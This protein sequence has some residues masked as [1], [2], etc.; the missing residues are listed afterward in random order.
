MD[1]TRG[2][3][4]LVPAKPD[5]RGPNAT[6]PFARGCMF[7]GAEIGEFKSRSKNK[8]NWTLGMGKNMMS[9][10]ATV[11]FGL[12][13]ARPLNQPDQFENTFPD[14]KMSTSTNNYFP[15]GQYTTADENGCFILPTWLFVANHATN[16]T[17]P[18]MRVNGLTFV[19]EPG[20]GY[21][22]SGRGEGPVDENGIP[23]YPPP[24]HL[25]YLSL[26]MHERAVPVRRDPNG[27][28]WPQAT[29]MLH[30]W[31]EVMGYFVPPTS[32]SVN[33]VREVNEFGYPDFR[34]V[35][36]PE[37]G[38]TYVTGNYVRPFYSSFSD[39]MKNFQKWVGVV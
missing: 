27:L 35:P 15:D 14:S 31:V 28:F 29:R 5:S 38:Y 1:Q 6:H 16:N 19:I 22:D 2:D 34:N 7:G 23:T 20:T 39:V 13:I 12:P 30:N 33:V 26:H 37:V 3:T 8:R 25:S 4:I 21:I 11:T 17:P 36:F 9:H 18:R 24:N 32:L 10:W